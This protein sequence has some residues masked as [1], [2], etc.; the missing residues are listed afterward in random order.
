MSEGDHA[1]AE[2]LRGFW[3]ATFADNYQGLVA[4]ARQLAGGGEVGEDVT[5]DALIKI[6]RLVPD[7]ATV[8]DTFHYLK[9][10]VHNAWADWLRQQGKIKTVSIDDPHNAAVLSVAAPD[11]DDDADEADEEDDAYRLVLENELHRLSERERRLL[12]L[13]LKG[14][15]CRKIAEMLK[16]DVRITRHDLNKVWNRVHY[17]LIKGKVKVKGAGRK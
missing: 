3:S 10:S 1:Q 9:R 14:H 5:H 2:H 15:K 4:Y 12:E 8:E 13:R 17:H 7:P 6:L 11:D 16:E